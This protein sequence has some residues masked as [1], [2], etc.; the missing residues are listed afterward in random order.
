MSDSDDDLGKPVDFS[1]LL[2]EGRE[3]QK[4]E[5]DRL[6]GRIARRQVGAD[7]TTF[8]WMMPTEVLRGFLQG[9]FGAPLRD[10][11]AGDD[12]EEDDDG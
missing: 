11:A 5:R 7:L 9:M 8:F 6:A 1:A 10:V 4:I 2:N 3:L 12:D